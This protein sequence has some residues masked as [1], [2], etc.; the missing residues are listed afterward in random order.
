MAKSLF[1]DFRSQILDAHGRA[2]IH[3]AVQGDP[4][5]LFA[6]TNAYSLIPARRT[7]QSRIADSDIFRSSSNIDSHP[8]FSLAIVADE[9]VLNLIAIAAAKFIGLLS[10]ENPHLAILLDL[11]VSYDVVCVAVPDADSITSVL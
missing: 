9:A 11:A 8:R 1:V 10:K 6:N 7:L 2:F 4:L 5:S 3:I